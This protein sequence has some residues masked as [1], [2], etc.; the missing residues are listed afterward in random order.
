MDANKELHQILIKE[1]KETLVK[2]RTGQPATTITDPPNLHFEPVWPLKGLLLV[3]GS[4]LGGFGA[5]M[6]VFTSHFWES[7]RDATTQ[8]EQEFNVTK[9]GM[10]P[11]ATK[12]KEFHPINKSRYEFMSYD[13]PVS[14][15]ADSIRNIHASILLATLGRED[16]KSVLVSSAVSGEGKTFISVSLA[17]ALTGNNSKS[18]SRTS[19]RV[20]V[21]DCDMRRPS[22]HNVFSATRNAAG[23]TTLL[24]SQY[25]PA[26]SVVRKHGSI[27]GLF[28]MGA[29]PKV[30]DPAALLMSDHFGNVVDELHRAY[31][32]IV[33]D[34]PP[35]LGFPDSR[36]LSRYSD[37]AVVVMEEGRLHQTDLRRTIL[38][39][40]SA[41]GAPI[42][43]VVMNRARANRTHL[44]YGSY[45]YHRNGH[46]V[47]E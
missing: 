34:S 31:D 43:G 38:A 13:L 11:D 3:I 40:A 4:I 47:H 15:L 28:Y 16:V 12:L 9:L 14:P 30:P 32:F 6:A 45:Y 33:F 1:Y 25:M 10:V 2:A 42:L 35:I 21:V 37:F 17:T 27:P 46:I 5:V 8:L 22:I 39:L 20:L 36:I 18:N 44:M 41:P 19:T 29:G 7:T 23:L 26:E 24:T